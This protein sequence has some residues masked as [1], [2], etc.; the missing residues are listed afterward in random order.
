MTKVIAVT[1]VTGPR[2]RARVKNAIAMAP[3]IPM[4]YSS[5]SANR[6]QLAAV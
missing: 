5:G 1:V 3:W 4:A 2:C 6:L